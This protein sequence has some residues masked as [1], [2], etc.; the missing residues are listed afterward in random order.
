MNARTK[1]TLLGLPLLAACLDDSAS[2]L[3]SPAAPMPTIAAAPSHLVAVDVASES[4]LVWP[5]TGTDFHAHPQDPINLVFAG[6]ADPRNVRN[7]LLSLDGNR[8][9]SPFNTT[10]EGMLLA[11]IANGCRWTD[12]F[13]DVQATYSLDG[14]W[15]GSVLQLECGTYNTFRFH[16][17]LFPAGILTLG[18]VHAEVIIPGTQGHEV[19]TWEAAEKFVI[20]ELMRGELLA[21]PPVQS[22]V[23]NEVG[24]FK[25][26]MPAIYSG[27]PDG[28]PLRM[29]AGG[30]LAGE[31]TEPVPLAT[32]GRATILNL[33]TAPAASGTSNAFVIDFG[34]FIPKPFCAPSGE[35]I[36]VDGP[37]HVTHTVT[38]ASS[39]TVKSKGVAKGKLTVRSFDITTGA[40]GPPIPAEVEQEIETEVGSSRHRA[41]TRS[42]QRL[43]LE[44]GQSESFRLDL[45]VGSGETY[46]AAS[47]SCA[48]AK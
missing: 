9:V 13:G 19:L 32:D 24:S 11:G 17:R 12:A 3:L 37:V 46:F 34:Q 5:Y 28:H 7:A 6:H 44:H 2:V 40:L 16:L 36:R 8:N 15:A 1:V 48:P 39:G 21:A 43:L 31:V 35:W 27:L 38:V 33:R 22:A 18:N 14:G 20:M 45:R 25:G 4:H 26:I 23:I 42:E 41:T 29:L 10:A 47:Q 30:P